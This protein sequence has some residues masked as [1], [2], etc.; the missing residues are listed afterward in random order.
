[1]SVKKNIAVTLS[2]IVV[3]SF[4]TVGLMLFDTVSVSAA[5]GDR[6]KTIYELESE[7][8]GLKDEEKA[9]KA[10][11]SKSNAQA[12]S[13]AGE[14]QSL[15]SEISLLTAQSTIIE[16]L[17]SEWQVVSDETKAQIESLEEQKTAE[18]S[19]FDSMLRMSYQHGTDTY[20]NLIFGS[21]DIGDFLS[22]TDLLAY[23]FEA[24]D[25]VLDNLN[26][27]LAELENANAQYESSIAKL[28]EFGKEQ[29][30]LKKQ[31]EQ[32]EAYALQ[33]K[34]EYEQDAATK[35]AQLDAKAAELK[36][37]E[38]EIQR[39]YEESRRNDTSVYSG[40]FY[41]PTKNYRISSEFEWRNSP[42]N[43]KKELHNGI[44]FAAPAGTPIYAADDGTVIDSRYSSSWGNVIQ[45]DHGGGVVT[46]YAHCSARLASTGQTVKKG[47][48]IAKVGTTGWSTGNHLHFTV[49]KAGTAVNPRQYLGSI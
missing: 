1:M 37:M 46:L 39:R 33:K 44:D 40:V 5:S 41:T 4:V 25:N 47:E 36:E 24:N 12:A 17:F 20:F 38:R 18:L 30:E 19:A 48:L 43:G 27:T 22:R 8:S 29:E 3:M 21:E 6:N 13:Y 9:L 26:S 10:A 16:E 32:R 14:I 34:K 31:L 11:I 45:I 2:M 42:I 49:Y 15:D 23:H 28:S 7:L 35:Q